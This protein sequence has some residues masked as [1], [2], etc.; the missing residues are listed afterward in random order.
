M[1]SSD[2]IT[3]NKT[4]IKKRL[5]QSVSTLPE[6]SKT[7]FFVEW[8][9]AQYSDYMEPLKWL[10]GFYTNNEIYLAMSW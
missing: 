8:L 2:Q 6:Q 5:T 10:F 1:L 3:D 9:S 7:N 4:K